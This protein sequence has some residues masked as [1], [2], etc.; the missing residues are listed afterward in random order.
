MLSGWW[1][2][3]WGISEVQV[4]WNCWSSYRVTLLLSFFQLFPNSITGVPRFF[5]LVCCKYLH[6]TQLLVGP[7]RRQPCYTPVCKHTIESV[8]VPDLGVFSWYR[9][10]FGPVAGPPFP[11]TLLHVCPCSS[12]SEE[13]FWVRVLDC[14][15]V[16]PFFQVM[17]CLFIYF[18]KMSLF[19]LST[20][21]LSSDT[22]EEGIISH[23]EW[24]WPSM[25]LL[26]TE[27]RTSGRTVSILNHWAIS[28][29]WYELF[30]K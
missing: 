18:L 8:M 14:G 15:M 2:G 13:Q 5:F 6:L 19:Y 7:P 24:F 20:L 26:R 21:K 17:P 25:W 10:Q 28:P 23:Y 11:Q 12:F 27:L 3:V 16:A 29:D 9:S 1:L 22:P 30:K 4:S